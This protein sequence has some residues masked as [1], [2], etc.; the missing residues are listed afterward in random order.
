MDIFNKTITVHN[1][2]SEDENTRYQSTVLSGVYYIKDES[3]TL[4][5]PGSVNSDVLDVI[6]PKKDSLSNRTYIEKYKFDLL[7]ENEKENHYTLCSGDFLSLGDFFEDD[8]SLDE[9][10]SKTGNVYE[11][12]AVSDMDYGSLRHFEVY[13]H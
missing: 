8:L 9:Y 10:R 1:V 12:S 4:S 3:V 5:S 11:I 6:I 7:P 2:V 13:A